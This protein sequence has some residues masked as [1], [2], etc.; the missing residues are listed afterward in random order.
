MS[1]QDDLFPVEPDLNT[2]G[3]SVYWSNAAA[4][5]ADGHPQT[6]PA[7]VA[8]ADRS[9]CLAHT[10]RG[11]VHASLGDGPAPVTGDWI[12]LDDADR[13]VATLPR[14]T[15]FTRGAGRADTRGQVLAANVDL[16][17]VVHGLSAAPNLSRIERLLAL[18]WSGGATPVVVLTK[19]DLA[20]DP[21]SER[22]ETRAACPGVEVV[23]VSTVPQHPAHAGLHTL[24]TLLRP[25]STGTLVGPSGVGKSSL[26]NALVGAEVLLTRD[27]RADGKGRHTSVAR[28]LVPLPWGATLIDTPGLRGVQLWDAADGLDATFADVTALAEQCRF[29]DCAHDTEP[30]C[31]VRAA[32]ADGSLSPRRLASFAKLNREQEWLAA[33]YDARL[34]AEQREKWKALGKIG[35]SRAR[36]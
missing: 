17:W 11:A 27:I 9:G 32:V 12:L 18:A 26:V 20:A 4:A 31:T 8:R 24:R 34:R 3:W 19:A 35:R 23:C 22:D 29:R 7:R 33:R 21:D 15:A 10:A 36:P 1:L 2:L 16:V 5:F 30:G 25:G 28:E 6:R 14:R 13:V